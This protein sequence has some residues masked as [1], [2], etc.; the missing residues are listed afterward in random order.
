MQGIFDERSR[1]R[2]GQEKWMEEREVLIHRKGKKKSF[3]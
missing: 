2:W 3:C 1:S